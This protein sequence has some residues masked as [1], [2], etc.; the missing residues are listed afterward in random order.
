[1]RKYFPILAL[2]IYLITTLFLFFLGPIQ[3]RIYNSDLFLMTMLTYHLAT[4]LGYYIGMRSYNSSIYMYEKKISSRRFYLSFCFALLS[5]LIAYKNIM[6][7]DSLI[8]YN[9]LSDVYNGLTKPAQVYLERMQIGATDVRGSSS[10]RILNMLSLGFAFFKL[11]FI[12]ETYY[13][14]KVLSFGKKLISIT[15]FLLFISCGLASGTNS[16]IFIF[17]IFS[18]FSLLILIYFRKPYLF[19]TATIILGTLF[20]IPIGFFGFIMSRRGGGFEYFSTTARYG[21]ITAPQGGIVDFTSFSIE[22][23]IDFYYY[24]FVWLTYYLVQGYYGF[25]LIL[26][27]DKTWTFGF[28]NSDFLQRQLLKLT[29]IDISD[30]TLQ[31]QI[32]D[33]WGPAQWHSFYGHFANDFG[34][35]GLAFFLFLIGFFLARVWASTIYNNSFYGKALLPIF[36]LMFVFFPANN[37]VFGY[38]DTLSYFIWI[39]IFWAFERNSTNK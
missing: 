31:A 10:M 14:W 12:F 19:K 37:Q 18:I 27:L 3:F 24:S 9:L 33:K 29:G 32:S 23:F 4:I 21:D 22:I 1:M 2:E 36:I 16:V 13:Y 7:S 28:G 6:L 17:F 39:S 15:Y 11:L 8:P 25:A 5:V 26:N 38:I 30:A 35:V 20:L 34:F